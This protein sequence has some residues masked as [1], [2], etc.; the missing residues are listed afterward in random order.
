MNA[1]DLARLFD[2]KNYLG[3]TG[4]MIERVLKAGEERT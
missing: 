4:E 1:E 3:S 2:P